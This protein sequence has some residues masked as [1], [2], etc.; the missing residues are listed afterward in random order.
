M[1]TEVITPFAR[2]NISGLAPPKKNIIPPTTSIR[3]AIAGTKIIMTNLMI[4]L[5]MTKKWQKVQA[6]SPGPPQGTRPAACVWFGIREKANKNK[7][8][9]K[10]I[11]FIKFIL[12]FFLFHDKHCAL[13]RTRTRNFCFEGKHDIHFT[14]RAYF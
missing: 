12:T 2:I 1:T 8:L 11:F 10:N 3:T 13:A 4:L 7:R 6:D 9:I 14:T 5:I